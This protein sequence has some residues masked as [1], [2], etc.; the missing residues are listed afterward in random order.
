M[1]I[2]VVSLFPLHN[3]KFDGIFKRP[4]A[5]STSNSCGNH[6]ETV[7]FRGITVIC[8]LKRSFRISVSFAISLV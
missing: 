5:M 7:A 3:D 1:Y 4:L 2:S 8:G 6:T